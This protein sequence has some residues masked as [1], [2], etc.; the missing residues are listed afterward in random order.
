MSDRRIAVVPITW[1]VIEEALLPPGS[2]L[3]DATFNFPMMTL[4]LVVEHPDLEP[5]LPRCV[6]PTVAV[7][8]TTETVVVKETMSFG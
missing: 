8:V 6:P 2:R 7:Q 4:D 1:D 3:R 5:V